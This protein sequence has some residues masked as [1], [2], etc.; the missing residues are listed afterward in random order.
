MY[1]GRVVEELPSAIWQRPS[2]LITLAVEL[3]ANDCS[4]R[5]PIAG[6]RATGGVG[7][8]TGYALSVRDMVVTFD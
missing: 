6:A 3:S 2:I 7:A 5:P 4:H 1:A 8:M